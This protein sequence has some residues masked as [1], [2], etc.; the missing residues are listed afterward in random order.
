LVADQRVFESTVRWAN[1][2]LSGWNFCHWQK[3]NT[4]GTARL[5][6]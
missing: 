3:H 4:H 2:F 5:Q 6:H 1:R